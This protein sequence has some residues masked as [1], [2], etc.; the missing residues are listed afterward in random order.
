V[1]EISAAMRHWQATPPCHKNGCV[2][3]TP[4]T[5]CARDGFIA[6]SIMG[7]RVVNKNVNRFSQFRNNAVTGL[8]DNKIS[9]KRFAPGK[10]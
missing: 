2:F 5:R 6:F 10:I 1:I 3:L 8:K 7:L 4:L 9:G